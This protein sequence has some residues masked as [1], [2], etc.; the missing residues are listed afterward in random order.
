MAEQQQ[1]P[2]TD[3][4]VTAGMIKDLTDTAMPKGTYIHARNA[5]CILPDGQTGLAL[6]TEPANLLETTIP[7]TLIGSIPLHGDLWILFSTDNTYSEIGQYNEGTGTYITMLNDVATIAAGM[8]GMGFRTTNLISGAARRNFD[9][10]FDVYWSDGLNFNRMLDTQYQ[11]PNPWVQSCTTSATC[12]TCVNTNLIDIEQLRLS[13]QFSVPCLKLAKST[14]SG[15][16]LNGSY[17]VCLRYAI[18][19]IPCTDFIALSNVQSIFAHGNSAGAVV[20]TVSN[21]NTETTVIFPEYEIVVV[22]MVNF[23]VQARRLGIYNSTQ[24][25]IYIDNL[26][27]ELVAI[28]LKLLPISNP[29]IDKSDAIFSISNYL[30]QSGVYEKPE[31]NYQPLANQ[32]QAYWSC[33][34]YPADYYHKGGLNGFPMNVGMQRGERYAAFIRWVY[35]TGDKSASYPI[36]GLPV[37]TAATL[38]PGGPSVG[39]GSIPIAYGRFAGYSSTELYPSNEPAVWGSLCGMPIMHH[40]FPDQATFGGTILS[41]FNPNGL[42]I[43]GAD[44]IGVMG[45]FFDNIQ[46]PVDINGNLIPNIQ[47]YEILRAVRNGHEHILASGMVNNMRVVADNTGARTMFSNYPYNDLGIDVFLTTNALNV[48]TGATGNGFRDPLP[49]WNHGGFERST[50]SF[51]SPDTTFEQPYLGAGT[52]EI[53][54]TV[55]GTSL[56]SFQEPY[57]HPMFKVLTDFDS[58]LGILIGAIEFAMAAIGVLAAATGGSP[59]ATQLAPTQA[60]PFTI[61][62]FFDTNYSNDVAATDVS[63]T[64]KFL[65]A[66]ANFVMA[67]IFAPIQATIIREQFLTVI[68][69][70]IPGR[71]YVAQYNS[72]GFYNTPGGLQGGS[73]PIAVTDYSYI[74]GQTQYFAGVTVNNLYRNNYVALQLDVPIVPYYGDSQ[75]RF[76]LAAGT[77]SLGTAYQR[78]IGSYYGAYKVPQSAQYGQVDSAK[79]VP[80]S[81]MMTAVP[82]SAAFF[83]SPVLFGGDIYINRFTEKNPFFFFNDWLINVPEDFTYDYRNYMNVPYPMFWINNDVINYTLLG[84]AHTNRRLDGPIN[85]FTGFISGL[86]GNAFYVNTGYFYLFCNGIRDFYVESTV[87]VGYRDWEDTIPKMFYD[88][89]G[90]QDIQQIFRSDII[91]S[92]TLYKYDYSL[93]ADKFFNQYLSWSKCLDRDYDPVLAYTCYNYYPRRLAYSLPQEEEVKKDNWKVFL[94]NNYKDMPAKVTAI[95]DINKTGAIILLQDQAPLSFAG[96]ETIPSKSGTEFS[97]GTGELFRQSLQSITNVDDSYQYGSC[98]GRLSVVSTPHG[99]YWISQNTGK[100]FRYSPGENMTDITDGIRYWLSLYM[101]SQL[102][103]QFPDYPYA[104]NPVA[105]IGTQLIYDDINAI[106]YICKKD[107]KALPGVYLTGSTFHTAYAATGTPVLLGNPLY[108]TDCSWTLS[109]DVRA[110]KWLSFQDWHPSLNIA[111]KTHFLTTETTIGRG[112]TIWRH[113]KATNQF[114]NYYGIDHPFEIEYPI[115]TGPNVTTLESIEY[116]ME[117]YLYQSNHVDKFQQYSNGFNYA[118]VYNSEQATLPLIMVLK[119]W[120]DPYGSLAY[121][122]INA[123]GANI[124]YTKQEQRYRIGMMLK[125]MTND[126]GEF[127]LSTIQLMQTQDNGYTWILN[128]LYYNFSK[129]PFEQKKIR[130]FKSRIFLRRTI[131]GFNSMSFYFANTKN[132]NSFR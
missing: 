56:G 41:H 46:P 102:L 119:P 21:I 31:F 58:V 18:N 115:T 64:T 91:K 74:K 112:N 24:Q 88:P 80:V 99:I 23:Q 17:Q 48:A 12:I 32:I 82:G 121:P 26:D 19:S 61:P 85:L 40:Q 81:C 77:L 105:G 33:H 1:N 110:R 125:D 14:G 101:P 89:Y 113:N 96:V 54:M 43:N 127:D 37:G 16:L 35:T 6:H 53:T 130:H 7:Y 30:I 59:I 132:N 131:V 13:P 10:G 100:V 95:R 51:H 86:Q 62:L 76:N 29:I 69:G 71:Q 20:C 39:D 124:Y 122:T 73:Y 27:Q 36:P 11:Y 87:N 22:S 8:P 45:W 93:S 83:T 3:N 103:K 109:Y 75:S 15:S 126:R 94:P 66:A 4:Q 42:T 79:Q 92:D 67:A 123:T 90:F 28:D 34:A 70:L 128:P 114:C 118:L 55:N 72:A 63:S 44:T 117:S 106:L 47:G 107:Y 65:Q 78:Q 116:F 50:V 129:S 108:F 9:C 111:A 57:K 60:I 98:Q 84:L 104:D 5:T 52:L 68:K 25:T 120:D 49:D 2:S 97:V 38:I